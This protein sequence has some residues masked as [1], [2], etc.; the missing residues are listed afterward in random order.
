[1]LSA[2]SP[3]LLIVSDLHGSP[4]S[5]SIME[6]AIHELRP[7][8]CVLLGDVLYHGPRNPLPPGYLPR[9]VAR[10]LGELPIP[11]MA[12]RGNC[13]AEVDLALLPFPMPERLW[14]RAGKLSILAL[15]GHTLLQGPLVPPP[16]P[17]SV[18]LSGHTH[19]PVAETRDGLHWWNPGSITLPKQG[20]P[21][22]YG[23]FAQGEF[24]IMDMHG[25]TFM[26]HRPA[27]A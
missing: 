18:I 1:M 13:D 11:I 25:H 20:F 9:D 21:R 7:E 17:G 14:L 6:Q 16:P 19:L 22:S 23:F 24:Q 26:R 4:E 2:D 27:E 3:R 8:L 15:H 10:M 12:V 5:V